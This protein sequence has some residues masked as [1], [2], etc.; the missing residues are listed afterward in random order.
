MSSKRKQPTTPE[1]CT[2]KPKTITE[3]PDWPASRQALD[4]ARAFL[5]RCANAGKKT[6]I[7]PDKDADGLCGGSVVYRTLVHLGH[8]PA[9]LLVHF[10]RK[11]SNVHDPREWD[12]T[13]G[14]GFVIVVDQGS[15]AAR[16]TKGDA[17]VLVVDHHVAEDG[18]PPGAV[19]LSAWDCEPVVCA[20][21]L[22]YVLCAPLGAERWAWLACVGAMGDLGARWEEIVPLSVK[23][24][25]CSKKG[26]GEVVSLINA[27]RRTARYD[28]GSAWEVVNTASSPDDV[29]SLTSPCYNARLR[30]ARREV[31]A[32]VERCS[33][34]SAPRFSRD[35]RVA[36]LRIRSEAQVH[37]VVAT[38]W[39]GVLKS[40]KLE[41]VMAANDGYLPG[42]V[43]FSC[44]VARVANTRAKERGIPPPNIIEILKGYADNAQ[45]GNGPSLRERLGDNFARGHKEASGGIVTLELFGKLCV[46][47]EIGVKDVRN[48][49]SKVARTQKNTLD[50]WLDSRS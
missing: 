10:V 8:P 2:K 20:A 26:L 23:A 45:V 1:R 30:E 41:V 28:V 48:G 25:R 24:G 35:G 11:G 19:V 27:P 47:M 39:A 31:N 12:V 46:A 22:A 37:P 32:E 6:L 15:R 16:V 49:G 29:V 5:R 34:A 43:N 42:M 38:R 44:R 14:V 3:E 18:F 33:R 36:M 4:A 21:V 17:E 9:D 13:E 50:G 40:S 7:L